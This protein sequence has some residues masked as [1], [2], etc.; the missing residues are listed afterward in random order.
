MDCLLQMFETDIILVHECNISHSPSSPNPKIVPRVRSVAPP[1]L[2]PDCSDIL[3]AIY[4]GY[5][6][7]CNI[8]GD[9]VLWSKLFGNLID[10]F[11]ED[12]S[13]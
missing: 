4:V 1:C 10:I 5:I 2:F 3:S 6:H 12:L 11:V 8:K 7:V 13:C 9:I